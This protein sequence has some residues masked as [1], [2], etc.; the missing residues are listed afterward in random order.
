MTCVAPACTLN[1]SVL[2][3]VVV[4]ELVDV[5]VVEEVDDVVDE[6][7]VDEEAASKVAITP[8]Q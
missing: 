8:A 1:V 5:V 2:G 7:V 4:E 6:D 3:P